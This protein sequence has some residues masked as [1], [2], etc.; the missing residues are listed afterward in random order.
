MS[1][2]GG[3]QTQ[4][5]NQPALGVRGDFASANPWFTF[6]AGPGGLVAAAGGV[7]IGYAG[8]A[9]PPTDPNSGLTQVKNSGFGPITGIIGRHQQG[10][11]STFLSPAGMAILEGMP[12]ALYTGGDFVVDNDGVSEAIAGMKM[13]A[14][15]A[16][17]KFTFGWA[18][19]IPGGASAVSTAVV[20]TTLTLVGS[21]ENNIL[22]VASVSAGTVYP[23]AVLSSNAFG[24]ITQQLTGTPGGAGTYELTVGNQSV[25]A[26][27]TIGGSYG[28]MTLGTTTGTFTTGMVLSGTGVPAYD[29]TYYKVSGDGST[30]S[31]F[32]TSLVDAVSSATITG[33]AAIETKW[34]AMNSAA[35][36]TK[37]SVKVSS[38]PIG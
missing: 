12:L 13:F 26:G 17:G 15:L 24:Q 6:D 22:T 8:W 14:R 7:L 31:V 34:Q 11:N 35:A 38:Q 32:V 29:T 1:G 30:G 3:F 23:G 5:Y 37:G 33:S 4:V 18:G 10:L 2:T 28:L 16:D 36:G 27:T 21:V 9:Y 20:K 25:P 19:S